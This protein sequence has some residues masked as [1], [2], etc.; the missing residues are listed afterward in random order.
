M[1]IRLRNSGIILSPVN[2]PRFLRMCQ[3]QKV[4]QQKQEIPKNG[5]NCDNS[6]RCGIIFD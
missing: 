5:G 1:F 4:F 6:M 2:V 3:K